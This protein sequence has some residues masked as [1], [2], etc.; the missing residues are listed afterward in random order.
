[1]VKPIN[2]MFFFQHLKKSNFGKFP[3]GKIFRKKNRKIFRRKNFPKKVGKSEKSEIPI[4]GFEQA[5]S[6]HPSSTDQINT[7]NDFIY[8]KQYSLISHQI[9]TFP[10]LSVQKTP[11]FVSNTSTAQVG[12]HCSLSKVWQYD[13]LRT[14]IKKGEKRTKSQKLFGNSLNQKQ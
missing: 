10:L 14:D 12:V 11:I 9:H 1:M 5:W 6:I 2:R 7:T 8:L 13:L 4:S 3:I